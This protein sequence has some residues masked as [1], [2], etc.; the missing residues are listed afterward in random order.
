[1]KLIIENVY[2]TQ[3]T[4]QDIPSLKELAKKHIEQITNE[5]K[6]LDKGQFTINHLYSSMHVVDWTENDRGEDVRFSIVLDKTGRGNLTARKVY[7][8][9]NK[10]CLRACYF[11]TK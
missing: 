3:S 5:I 6:A 4:N 9:S 10:T 11:T 7:A 1:M 2:N 8:I